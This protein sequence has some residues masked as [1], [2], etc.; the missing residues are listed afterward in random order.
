MIQK[1]NAMKTKSI[2]FKTIAIVIFFLSLI[3]SQNIQSAIIDPEDIDEKFSNFL[4]TASEL[5][6]YR[7]EST[8][9]ND[10]EV[11]GEGMRQDVISQRWI[12]VESEEFTDIN[13]TLC[14]FDSA[15]EAIYG[16]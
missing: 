8:K 9:T 15:P 1:R 14:V 7:L 16:T 4:I 2:K 13:I 12:A 6:G 5:P 11:G 10:W 3:T